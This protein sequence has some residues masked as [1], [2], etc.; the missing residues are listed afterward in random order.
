MFE[1]I[2]ITVLAVATM[3]VQ[4]VQLFFLLKKKRAETKP[5]VTA[6]D[7]LPFNI[8]LRLHDL[9]K[10]GRGFVHIHD[11]ELAIAEHNKSIKEVQ[12]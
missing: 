10:E 2:V 11:I 3:A 9:S 5:L 8:L 7:E 6:F 4:G 1:I 12:K